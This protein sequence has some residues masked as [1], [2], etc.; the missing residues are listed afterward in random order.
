MSRCP[1]A[2]DYKYNELGFAE[3]PLLHGRPGML[4]NADF[5][6][7]EKKIHILKITVK[8]VL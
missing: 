8:F 7:K 4:T 5:F 6:K 2:V 1:D 3:L